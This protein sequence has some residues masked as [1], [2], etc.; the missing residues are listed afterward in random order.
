MLKRSYSKI[1]PHGF[2]EKLN[3]VKENLFMLY[4]EYAKTSSTSS[5]AQNQQSQISFQS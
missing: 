2:Q 3:V 5:H 1:D 4:E